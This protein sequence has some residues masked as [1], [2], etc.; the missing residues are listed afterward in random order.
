[1]NDWVEQYLMMKK[2]LQIM[3]NSILKKD[4][5]SAISA[6]LEIATD[7]RLAAKQIAIQNEDVRKTV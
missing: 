2:N 5:E 4:F 3:H 1:M 6:A 7:A